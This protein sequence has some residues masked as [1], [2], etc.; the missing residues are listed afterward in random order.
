M[1]KERVDRAR[2]TH[3]TAPLP[4]APDAGAGF[5]RLPAVAAGVVSLAAAAASVFLVFQLSPQAA[6]P[7]ATVPETAQL[8]GLR[9]ATED[10]VVALAAPVSAKAAEDARTRSAIE[11]RMAE[12]RERQAK[13]V[14]R[15]GRLAALLESAK[16]HKIE[17]RPEDVAVARNDRQ[18]V[19]ASL[20]R[21]PVAGPRPLPAADETLAV[22]TFNRP[23]ALRRADELD[24]ALQG[25]ERTQDAVFA[26]LEDAVEERIE[27]LASIPAELGLAKPSEG[28][29][30]PFLE[31]RGVEAPLQPTDRFQVFQTA[32]EQVG[33]LEEM[34]DA[35]P[36]RLPLARKLTVTSGYG[37]RRDPFLGTPAMH[38]GID[39]AAPR[40]TPVHATASGTVTFAEWNGG[41]GRM[42]EIDHGN[43]HRTRYGHLSKIGVQEGEK[44]EAGEVIGNVGS[45]GRSTGP[46]LHYE[47]VRDG[48]R[49]DPSP[50][51]DVAKLIG[52]EI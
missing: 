18:V 22:N 13:L 51:L 48:H 33:E 28:T 39:L 1:A 9:G 21:R 32:L 19:L 44:V 36:V 7:E 3:Y 17:V 29:G 40:G 34:V 45:T 35:L 49:R 37:R 23:P 38:T 27:T 46:H 6:A 5:G 14:R 20:S 42:I 41:Y 24:L 50:Y 31:L 16:A 15:Q 11:A 2:L 30:G 43:G 52:K 4:A 25:L 47:M 10:P 8:I 12:L 26:A